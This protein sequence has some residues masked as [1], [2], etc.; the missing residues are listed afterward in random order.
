V[1]LLVRPIERGVATQLSADAGA[2]KV[3]KMLV[4]LNQPEPRPADFDA[5]PARVSP[6]PIPRPVP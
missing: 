3:I 6:V 4:G 1:Q 5:P 2:I